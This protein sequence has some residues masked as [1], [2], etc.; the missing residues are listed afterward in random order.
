MVRDLNYTDLT[1][2]AGVGGY[3]ITTRLSQLTAVFLLSACVTLRDRYLWQTPIDEI[4]ETEYMN[5]L[6][7]IA[8]AEY[9]LMTSFAIGQII[10]TVT[11]QSSNDNLIL[12]DGSTIDG[13]D[14]PELLAEVPSAWVSGSDITLPNMSETGV[15]GENGDVGDIVGEND[16][17]LSTGELPAHNHTQDS[18]NHTYFQ[19]TPTVVAGGE[20]PTTA[21]FTVT[22]P[23]GSSFKTPT[24]HNTGN[25][26]A[27]NN[28]QASLSVY[29]YIVAR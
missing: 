20:I 29:W 25:D 18:H 7:M 3:A 21:T 6:D 4:S 27:H 24:I 8:V 26:E 17:Q 13:D 10:S 23:N 9:E 12:M 22:A 1:T 2:L 14:Y 16:V 19:A 15:F 28:I 5:I 11:D